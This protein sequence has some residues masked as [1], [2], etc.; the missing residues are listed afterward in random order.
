MRRPDA[1]KMIGRKVQAWTAANGVY[2][3]YLEEVTNS[4]PWRAKVRITGVLKVP[5]LFEFGRLRPDQKYLRNGFRPGD[6]IEVGGCNCHPSDEYGKSYLTALLDEKKTFEGYLKMYPKR[7][8]AVPAWVTK[9]L[10]CIEAAIQ[11]EMKGFP[12][13]RGVSP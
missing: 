8:E 6:L 7:G 1:L 4:R 9:T 5:T 13:C 11:D 3:G 12:K 10:P 2:V